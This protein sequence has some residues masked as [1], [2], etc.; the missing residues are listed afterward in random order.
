MFINE[1]RSKTRNFNFQSEFSASNLS[2]SQHT[3]HVQDNYSDNNND[4]PII[5]IKFLFQK[6]AIKS[7]FYDPF[8]LL[9]SRLSINS[10]SQVHLTPSSPQCIFCVKQKDYFS[11]KVEDIDSGLLSI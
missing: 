11:L 9:M 5:K 8:V 2:C 1:N 6:S 7:D 4:I 10:F 3:Y